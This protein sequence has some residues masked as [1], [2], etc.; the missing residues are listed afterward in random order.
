[1]MEL[2]LRTFAEMTVLFDE[3]NTR[4]ESSTPDGTRYTLLAV[5][6]IAM[7]AVF[8]DR[9]TQDVDVVTPTIPKAVRKAIRA[10]AKAHQ[11]P[12]QWVNNDAAGIMN[13]DLPFEAFQSIYSNTNI[14]V[15]AVKPE[16]LLG[17]KLMSGRDKDINDLVQLAEHVG[18]TSSTALLAIYDHVY[19][20]S[21][22]YSTQRGFVESVCVD[23]ARL[24]QSHLSGNDITSDI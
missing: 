2:P 22:A 21:P 4:L 7:G 24:V 1:M 20:A 15:L 14:E 16:Y 23:I 13:V 9:A 18:A 6:G 19:A 3:M 5:G 17:L 11:M 10:V 8:K 12:D